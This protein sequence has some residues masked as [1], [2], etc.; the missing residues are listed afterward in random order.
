MEGQG[1]RFV[2]PVQVR[3]E[4]TEPRDGIRELF[5]PGLPVRQWRLRPVLQVPTAPVPSG[6][7]GRF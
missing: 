1:E 3:G 5:T 4:W 6:Q 2:L 7:H